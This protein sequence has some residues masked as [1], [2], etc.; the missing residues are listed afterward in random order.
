[1]PKSVKV[2]ITYEFADGLHTTFHCPRPAKITHDPYTCKPKKTKV[3]LTYEHSKG[4][5]T[6]VHLR[7]EI[8]LNLLQGPQ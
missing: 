3:K 5:Q 7:Q 2:K 6:T 1:M 4:L 8:I